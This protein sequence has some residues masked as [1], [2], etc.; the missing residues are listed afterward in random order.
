[1]KRTFFQPLVIL[2]VLYAGVLRAQETSPGHFKGNWSAVEFSGF[3]SG[4]DICYR[5]MLKFAENG[6]GDL[7][8]TIHFLSDDDRFDLDYRGMVPFTFTVT[9]ADTNAHTPLAVEVSYETATFPFQEMP[10]YDSFHIQP[11]HLAYV[12]EIKRYFAN[13]RE[14]YPVFSEVGSRLVIQGFS[15]VDE[16]SP[17]YFRQGHSTESC[18]GHSKMGDKN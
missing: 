7:W 9:E 10:K 6:L 16:S 5:Y 13:R 18:D 4:Q 1:M 12:E 17:I 11:E 2:L 14:V 15:L 8:L 3:R